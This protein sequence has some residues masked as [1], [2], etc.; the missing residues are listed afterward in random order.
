MRKTENLVRTTRSTSNINRHKVQFRYKKEE[1]WSSR[2]NEK[3]LQ[4][5]K[6]EILPE[7]KKYDVLEMQI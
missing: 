2:A 1:K 5:I 4:E 7:R 3:K 6:Y